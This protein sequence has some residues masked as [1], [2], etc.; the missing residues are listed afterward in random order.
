MRRTVRCVAA[1]VRK[2]QGGAD[3]GLYAL[4]DRHAVV[5]RSLVRSLCGEPGRRRGNA[6]GRLPHL[7]QESV[8]I[9]RRLRLVV[10]ARPEND[11]AA[12]GLRH[13]RLQRD[14]CPNGPREDRARNGSGPVVGRRDACA[15]GDGQHDVN[16]VYDIIKPILD[17]K[18]DFTIGSRFIDKTS[19]RFKST[20]ARQIGI[21]V[22]SKAI[23]I[24]THKKV[25]DTTSG[26][27]ACNKEIIK[28][29]SISYPL[30]YPEPV[31]TTELLKKGYKL[32]EVPVSMN[33]RIGGTSSIKAWK[34]IYYMVNVCLSIL[35]VKIRRY[36]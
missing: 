18:A 20:V 16:C 19:S 11:H 13:A 7:Q 31:T 14:L 3:A 28:S 24:S 34:N 5:V 25:F 2:A 4:A 23:N 8:G 29:F 9:G 22:I 1:T 6:A 36:K 33:E 32:K 26:F 15:A 21:R 10:P 27:R 12:A 17:K 30:E 35:M